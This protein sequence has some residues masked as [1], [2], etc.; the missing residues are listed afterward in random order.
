MKQIILQVL[1]DI[2]QRKRDAN[3]F[4]CFVLD[5]ELRNAVTEKVLK[6]LR[7]LWKEKY[8]RVGRTVNNNF[9]ELTNPAEPRGKEIIHNQ[10]N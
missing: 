9:I 3:I 10:N 6:T 5:N 2:S 1:E 7:E 8:I 4:P